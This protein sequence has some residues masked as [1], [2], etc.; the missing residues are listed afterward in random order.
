MNRQQLVEY[1]AI[2]AKYEKLQ[3]ELYTIIDRII[4]KLNGKER[5]LYY[6]EYNGIS[7][8]T[9]LFESNKLLVDFTGYYRG[10]TDN[11]KIELPIYLIENYSED[12]INNF[13]QEY[14]IEKERKREEQQKIKKQLEEAKLLE[15]QKEQYRSLYKKFNGV[16]PESL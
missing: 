3:D 9:F 1:V 10:D 4:L 15:V 14:L 11:Y 6:G 16:L 7:G 5:N 12:T 13:L 8:I 2:E